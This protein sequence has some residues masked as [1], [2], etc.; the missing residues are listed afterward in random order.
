[1]AL[2]ASV[3]V[4][5]QATKW[6]DMYKVKKKDTLFGISQKYGITV[7]DLKNANPDMKVEGYELKKGDYIFIPYAKAK[8]AATTA[9]TNQSVAKSAAPAKSVRVGIMLPLHNV[10]GDGRRMVEYYRGFLM[11]CDS[12]KQEGYSVDVHAWNVNVDADISQFTREPAAAQCDIIF[13][14]LYSVQVHTLA[15]FCKAHNIKMVIPFS[16]NGDEVAQYQQIYQVWQ[17]SDKLNNCAIEAYFKQ[18]PNAHPIFIDCNDKD[19]KKG[20]FTFAMRNRLGSK[21]INYNITNLNSSEM[22]F[23]KAFDMSKQ[24]VV[25]LNTASSSALYMAMSK[26]ESLKN[27]YPNLRVSFFGYTEWLMYAD[28]FF[29]NFCRLDTYIPSTFYYNPAS[30][31]TRRLEANYRRWFKA[32]LQE[33]YNPRFAITGYDHAQFFIRGWMKYGKNFKGTLG[34]SAYQALQT[35]LVFKQVN[36]KGMQNDY[37]Q[38]IHYTKKGTIESISY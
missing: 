4:M 32:E 3:Q 34:Q 30:W 22:Q 25:I 37:F 28:S 35:P 36:G 5:A 16:I 31:K 24:N 9:T 17:S 33:A 18:F 27:N 12:L 8:P 21:N 6:Q 26:I 19:S 13:G 29:K 15:E 23:A 2:A 1:M 20:A 14:P 10:D 7:D 38:L 11:A